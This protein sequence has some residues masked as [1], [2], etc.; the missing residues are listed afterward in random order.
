MSFVLTEIDGPIAIVTLNRPDKHNAFDDALIADLTAHLQA[1]DA[2][3]DVRV[4][5][6]SASGKSFSAGADLHWMKRMAGYSEIE[7][8]QDAMGLA[9]LMKTLHS[10]GKPTVA[11][12]QG[13][14]YGGGVGLVACCDIAVGTHEAAFSLSE[15]RLGLIPAVISPYVI[16]AIGARAAS[17][18]FLTAERFDAGEAYRL[19][20]LHELCNDEDEMDLKIEALVAGV[21]AA[22]PESIRE[23]KMLID[24]VTNAPLSNALIAD[25]AARIARVR[26]SPEGQEGVRAFLEK[27]KPAWVASTPDNQ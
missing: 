18:Y 4:V 12:V 11:R 26:V 5:V 9:T 22:G 21:L 7:N 3:D 8:Q 15:V 24:A 20:L 2:R 23:A 14:A 17:R 6:L 25:T 16:N 27:R 10:L 1:V 13:A 19:G